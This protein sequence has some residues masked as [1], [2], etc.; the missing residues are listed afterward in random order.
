[1]ATGKKPLAGISILVTRARRQAGEFS[2]LLRRQGATVVEIP[3]I[4]IVPPHSFQSLDD[5]LKT[6][7][8]YRWLVLTSVNGVTATLERMRR[9]KIPRADLKGL[10][11]AAIGSATRQALE[12][13]G[14]R[15][16]VTPREYVAEAVV[17]GLRNKVRGQRVLLVR[18]AVAR[19]VIPRKLRRAG[20]Q[21][22]VRAAYQTRSP[23]KLRARLRRILAD[24]RS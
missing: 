21:V 23:A 6:L 14:L 18:A 3:L 7:S 1:M 2:A 10:K 24:A 5:A 9:L 12:V 4:E 16:N 15:V 11:L 22:D 19:D 8:R 20:A 13:A 17:A